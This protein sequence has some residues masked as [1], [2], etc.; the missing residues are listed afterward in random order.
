MRSASPGSRPPRKVREPFPIDPWFRKRP[1]CHHLLLALAEEPWDE[2]VRLALADWLEEHGENARAEY[3]RLHT[4]SRSRPTTLAA[5][6]AALEAEHGR[7]WLRGLP[8]GAFLVGG[9]AVGFRVREEHWKFRLE[10]GCLWL[11]VQVLDLSRNGIGAE[12]ATTLAELAHLGQLTSL[13]LSFN[14]I[15]DEGAK[16]VAA[17]SHL[18][19]LAFLD[20]TGNHIG[21]AGKEAIRQ[22][23]PF[24]CL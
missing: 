24:A 8:Q 13:D 2:L 4:A 9:L 20:L 5:R 7:E 11:D 6:V 17:S 18:G 15:G 14:H 12:G 19:H 21:D 10:W 22:R 16:A 3:M 1:G 23:W